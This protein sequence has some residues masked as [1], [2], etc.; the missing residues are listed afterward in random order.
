MKFLTFAFSLILPTMLWSQEVTV[1]KDS[2]LS[3]IEQAP[4]ENQKKIPAPN[5]QNL[6]GF[7]AELGFPHPVS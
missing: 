5:F 6:F 4:E 3:A 2:A 7:S 1:K